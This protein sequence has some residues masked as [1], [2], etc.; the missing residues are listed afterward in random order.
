MEL[1]LK[2][3]N[4]LLE[5]VKQNLEDMRA[6]KIKNQAHIQTLTNQKDNLA[7]K[8]EEARI[9]V[10]SELIQKDNQYHELKIEITGLKDRL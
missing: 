1:E 6:E 10:N 3:K 9:S 2:S 7:K 4:S 8:V 5:Q